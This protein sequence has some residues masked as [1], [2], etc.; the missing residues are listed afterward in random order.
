MVFLISS[1]KQP[2]FFVD[3][4]DILITVQLASWQK[5]GSTNSTTGLMTEHGTPWGGSLVELSIQVKARIHLEGRSTGNV[6]LRHSVNS[7]VSPIFFAL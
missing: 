4:A 6:Y 7:V 5:R 3:I 2:Q 1:W